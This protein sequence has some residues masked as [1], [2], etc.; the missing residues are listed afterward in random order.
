MINAEHIPTIASLAGQLGD[1]STVRAL[2]ATTPG[3]ATH[4]NV[5][6][7]LEAPRKR[8]GGLIDGTS[9]EKTTSFSKFKLSNF[10]GEKLNE[11]VRPRNLGLVT[12]AARSL[13]LRVGRGQTP[14]VAFTTW[15]RMSRHKRTTEPIPNLCP[16]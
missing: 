5:L 8:I 6:R 11:F 3:T 15:E 10:M 1:I 9:A 13:E 7:L 12:N 2:M 4:A 14:D 16:N